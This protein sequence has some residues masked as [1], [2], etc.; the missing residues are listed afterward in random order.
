MLT[1]LIVAWSAEGGRCSYTVLAIE[2]CGQD[3][4]SFSYSDWRH[5]N[6]KVP[7]FDPCYSGRDCTFESKPCRR[8]RAPQP[9]QLRR[10]T[11]PLYLGDP[12]RLFHATL[13]KPSEWV[14]FRA[15]RLYIFQSQF[16]G[17]YN[18]RQVRNPCNIRSYPHRRRR[19]CR[20]IAPH[21]ARTNLTR[22]VFGA[23][24][25]ASCIVQAH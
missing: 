22:R 20:S 10:A 15:W 6:N 14:V 1:T 25:Q 5:E 16:L 2:V 17:R 11:Q 4:H 8:R 3:I 23:N 21:G 19:A 13:W 12:R 7:P 9:L 24:C 18:G